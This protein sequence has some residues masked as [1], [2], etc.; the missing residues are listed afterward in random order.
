M[1]RRRLFILLFIIFAQFLLYVSF[2]FKMQLT[3]FDGRIKRNGTSE[4]MRTIK[5]RISLGR[6]KWKSVFEA[7]ADNEGPDQTAHPR[8]LIRAFVVR[9]KNQILF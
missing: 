4:K 9:L 1:L 5:G 3:H 7:F 6:A 2:H 8:S